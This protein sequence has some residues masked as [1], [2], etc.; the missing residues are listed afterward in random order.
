MT[1]AAWGQ[2]LR[3][4]RGEGQR[5]RPVR[6]RCLELGLWSRDAP[7]EAAVPRC[8]ARRAE[9]GEPQEGGG[10]SAL[11]TA[12][13][14]GWTPQP[15]RGEGKRPGGSGRVTGGRLSMSRAPRGS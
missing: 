4:L 15:R 9:A 3:G 10:V 7:T 13:V 2:L 14:S 11:Q 5:R 8:L 12:K 1:R 6:G